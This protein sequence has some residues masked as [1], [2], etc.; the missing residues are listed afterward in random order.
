[1]KKL[2]NDILQLRNS[3][4]NFSSTLDGTAPR[5]KKKPNRSKEIAPRGRQH[6]QKVG[7]RKAAELSGDIKRRLARAVTLFQNEQEYEAAEALEEII[8]LNAEVPAAWLLLAGI[9]EDDGQIDRALR[10]LIMAAHTS[11]KSTT[12]WI[13]AAVL[14][15]SQ[16]GLEREYYLSQAQF[17]YSAAIRNE[18]KSMECRRARAAILEE[19]GKRKTA[20]SEYRNIA[21]REPGDVDSLR[22][23]AELCIDHGKAQ[24]ALDTYK[25]SIKYFRGLDPEDA[26]AFDWTQVD[27][28]IT[29]YEVIAQYYSAIAELKS[30]SRWLLGREE[31]DFW[32][33][34]TFDDSEWD[35]DET[36]KAK[37]PGYVSGKY[38][39]EAYE[40]PLEFRVRLGVFRLWIQNYDEAL[41]C[42]VSLNLLMQL[43]M[44]STASL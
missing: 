35:I 43:L 18:P 20:I 24:V 41:V 39:P 28:Y 31:D 9:Y 27:T 44:T 7:V 33:S 23:L 26:E 14:A 40:L 2:R 22:R 30:L 5:T 13:N 29:L 36:R 34:I 8:R 21:T 32:D 15:E 10:C 38:P 12:P 25:E 16:H 37:V 17:C 1:M 4:Q 19:R 42:Q 6:G 3:N 11:T